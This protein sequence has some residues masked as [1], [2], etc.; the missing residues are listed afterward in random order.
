MRRLG[1]NAFDEILVEVVK[2]TM[3]RIVPVLVPVSV[4]NRRVGIIA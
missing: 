4:D 3:I 2:T 1:R